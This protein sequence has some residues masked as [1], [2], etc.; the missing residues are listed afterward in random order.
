MANRAY[1][2]IYNKDTFTFLFES[3]G[4]FPFFWFCLL[5]QQTITEKHPIWEQ[6]IINDDEDNDDEHEE[7]ED[8]ISPSDIIL[9]KETFNTNAKSRR[10]FIVNHIP[11]ALTLYDDFISSINSHLYDDAVVC[12]ELI[13]IIWFYDN[14]QEF[15]HDI[16]KE[17]EA[18]DTLDIKAIHFLD[19]QDLTNRGT[20]FTSIDNNDFAELASYKQAEIVR[21]TPKPD[22]TPYKKGDINSAIYFLLICVACSILIYVF[23]YYN[24][25]IG[26]TI[27]FYA[28]NLFFYFIGFSML[29]DVVRKKKILKK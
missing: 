28:I 5:D 27:F 10:V 1:L 24:L 26:A 4:A 13:E 8:T 18:L 15:V 20:G 29:I 11:E 22:N 12:I 17:I 6:L 23:H 9:T 7:I 14:V 19:I 16:T 25:P 21:N 3:K 2:S